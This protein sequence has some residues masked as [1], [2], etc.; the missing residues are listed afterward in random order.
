MANEPLKITAI[1]QDKLIEILRR[2]GSREV[3]VETFAADITAG[4]P[5]NEDGTI[6]MIEYAAWLL[7][8]MQRGI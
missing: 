5:V 8:E 4:S 2:S 6:N 7:R 1:D 3:S